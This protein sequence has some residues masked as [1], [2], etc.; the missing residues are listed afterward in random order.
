MKRYLVIYRRR[1]SKKLPRIGHPSD[2]KAG[3]VVTF[4]EEGRFTTRTVAEV[5]G[6]EVKMEP[7]LYKEMV[8]A[9]GCTALIDDL[10]EVLRPNPS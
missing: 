10:T 1:I 2:V 7:M 5:H 8:I 9:K 6:Q 4:I 3:D